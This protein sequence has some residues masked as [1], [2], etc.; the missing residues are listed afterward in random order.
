MIHLPEAEAAIR[1]LS[2]QDAARYLGVSYWTI[3][4]LRFRGELPSLKIKRRILIDKTDLDSYIARIKKT[5]GG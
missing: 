4:D 5:E 1:L 3:R 2:E